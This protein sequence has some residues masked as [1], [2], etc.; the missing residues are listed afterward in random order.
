LGLQLEKRVC[1]L[2]HEDMGMAV[3]VHDEDAFDRP[4]HSEIFIIVLQALETC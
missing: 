4:P 2:Q 3:I 1:D